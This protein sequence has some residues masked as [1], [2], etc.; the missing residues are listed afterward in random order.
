MYLSDDRNLG[1]NY[2]S[3]QKNSDSSLKTWKVP[4]SQKPNT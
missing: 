2:L 1:S 3:V 4:G